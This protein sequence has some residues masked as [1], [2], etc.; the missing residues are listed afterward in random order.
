MKVVFDGAC[1]ADGPITGVARAF[2]NGL[3]AYANAFPGIATLLVPTGAAVPV[4]PGLSTHA[5]PRGALRRQLALPGLLRQ[6]AADVLHSPVAAVPL[7]ATCPTIATLHD[8][9]WLHAEAGERSSR[10]RRFATVRSLRAATAV[11]A[12]SAFTFADAVTLR[13]TARG[14]HRIAHGIVLPQLDLHDPRR[15]PFLA[16]GDARPRKNRER[17]AAAHARARARDPGLPALRFVGPPGDYVDE[18][19]KAVLLRTCTAVVQCSLFEGFGMPVLEALAHGAPTI[20]STLP[21]F[22]EI[23]DDLATYV[24]P[25]DETA[26]AAAL[27]A[28]TATADTVARAEARHARATGFTAAATAVAWHELHRSLC[29]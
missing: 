14:V 25:R 15:G 10:W 11:I 24:D 18:A 9:P 26:I 2:L 12:P 7:R 22:R 19:A 23:A 21:P 17:I 28:A 20:C 13:G 6:L 27:L 1:L 16:L 5:A 29:Q 4:V 8:V 3:V